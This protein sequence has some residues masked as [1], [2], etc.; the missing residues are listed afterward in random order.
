LL[1]RVGRTGAAC[2]P[3]AGNAAATAAPKPN[4]NALRLLNALSFSASIALGGHI[5]A[6]L[7]AQTSDRHI[8][9]G[10]DV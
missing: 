10:F 3:A 5:A 7:F 9:G 1:N 2:A 8:G 4:L 6:L